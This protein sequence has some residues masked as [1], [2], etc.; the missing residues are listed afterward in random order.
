MLDKGYIGSI[1]GLFVKESANLAEDVAFIAGHN[2]C[3]TRGIAFDVPVHIQALD[4]SGKYIGAS[5]VQGRL[6]GGAKVT[7]PEGVYVRKI[8]A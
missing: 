1:G 7:I 8:G 2:R 3:A 6:C 4:G 5:S